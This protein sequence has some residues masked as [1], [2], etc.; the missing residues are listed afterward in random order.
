MGSLKTNLHKEDG[1]K[2]IGPETQLKAAIEGESSSNVL[3]QGL[4][5]E[6]EKESDCNTRRLPLLPGS[7][8]IL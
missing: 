1:G 4:F 5:V 2:W 3:T 6:I 8:E 7:L